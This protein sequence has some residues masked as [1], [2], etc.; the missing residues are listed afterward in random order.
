MTITV[1]QYAFLQ[2]WGGR[3]PAR[4]LVP[5]T[6]SFKVIELGPY[7]SSKAFHTLKATSIDA[8]VPYG[9][10]LL[11]RVFWPFLEPADF[12]PVATLWARPETQLTLGGVQ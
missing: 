2:S 3:P 11:Q 8:P 10:S 1:G 5:G 9:I 7:V 12:K 6:G 4:V